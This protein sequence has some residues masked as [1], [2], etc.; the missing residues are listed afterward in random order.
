VYFMLCFEIAE[1]LEID[2][3]YEVSYFVKEDA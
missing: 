3:G 1:E 2:G